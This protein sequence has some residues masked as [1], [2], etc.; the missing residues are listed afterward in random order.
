MKSQEVII[1]PVKILTE[2]QID[3]LIKEVESQFCLFELCEDQSQCQKCIE[4]WL[5]NNEG[6][7]TAPSQKDR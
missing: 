2:K 3:A 6:N 5:R 1:N 4:K 7:K